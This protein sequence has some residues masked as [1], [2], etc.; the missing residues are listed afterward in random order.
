M[1]QIN[2]N[3]II[4]LKKLLDN[5]L[6]IIS[7]NIIFLKKEYLTP[8]SLDYYQIDEINK[9]VQSLYQDSDFINKIIKELETITGESINKLLSNNYSMSYYENEILN[10]YA[11]AICEN[12]SSTEL[13]ILD[14]CYSK[15]DQLANYCN[16]ESF[17][18]YYKSYLNG[19]DFTKYNLTRE[20]VEKELLYI[21]NKR[22]ATEAHAVMRS[23][24]NNA[25]ENYF[26]YI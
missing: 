17:I 21:Y 7:E 18:K 23:L 11:K 15:D 9:L 25:P 3:E 14:L 22:G 24:I 19:I 4:K 13:E 6:D 1:L 16:R 2:P 5:S 26:E 10:Y 12:Y 20:Q 8:N